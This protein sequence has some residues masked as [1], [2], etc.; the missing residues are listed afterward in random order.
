MCVCQMFLH[1]IHKTRVRSSPQA[2]DL[3]KNQTPKQAPARPIHAA[4]H[5]PFVF[6]FSLCE[7]PFL[8]VSLPPSLPSLTSN[9]PQAA[10][11]SGPHTIPKAKLLVPQ[12]CLLDALSGLPLSPTGGLSPVMV[13]YGQLKLASNTAVNSSFFDCVRANSRLL[14]LLPSLLLPSLLLLLALLL[15]SLLSLSLL[16]V[17]LM[18]LWRLLSCAGVRGHLLTSDACRDS[19][20]LW[21]WWW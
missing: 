17:R 5:H 2:F 1:H 12:I 3:K 13:G 14:L 20:S 4:V 7:H 11:S 6:C 18:L 16:V 8:F 9:V 21:W 15:A 19:S 10:G